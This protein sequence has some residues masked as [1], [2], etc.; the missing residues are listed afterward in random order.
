MR[1][2]F[3][4]SGAF[5]LPT[6]ERLH[7]RGQVV[8]VISQPDRPAGRHQQLRPTPVAE[9]AL[10]HGLP[11]LR[12]RDVNSDQVIEQLRSLGADV[13]V[14]IAFGQK[15]SP[16]LVRAAGRLVIN[17]H[18]SLLPKYRGAAPINWAII[19]GEKETGL[20]VISVAEKI[21][22][23]LIYAQVATPIGPLETAG[24]L[25]DRLAAMGPDLIEKVLEDFQAGRL[26]GRPQDESQVTR[27]PRLSRAD[28]W[29]DFSAPAGV[30]V[31][32]IHGL[33]PWPGV[34]V[35][36]Q[37]AAGG[38][39]QELI[40]RRATAEPWPQ[41]RVPGSFAPGAFVDERRVAAADGLVHLLEVQLPGRNTVSMDEFLRAHRPAPG[42][43]LLCPQKP[44]AGSTVCGTDA[45]NRGNGIRNNTDRNCS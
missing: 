36:W 33:T 9:F 5:G 19:C 27:A 28:A 13:A 24:E 2:I 15:L 6:L 37:R 14:V 44:A 16:V 38:R 17:L 29:V 45:D 18:A 26:A 31:R 22:A 3:L 8:L 10:Q 35:E 30:V 41:E 4:G 40:L 25:H 7:Q 23:G 21:D 11:L 34:H 1:I 43:R 39:Q 12:C 32:R 20:S 42:D